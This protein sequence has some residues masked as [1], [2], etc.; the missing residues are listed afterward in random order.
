LINQVPTGVVVT[1]PQAYVENECT[2]GIHT[3]LMV[4]AQWIDGPDFTTIRLNGQNVRAYPSLVYDA[5]NNNSTPESR[6]KGLAADAKAAHITSS[7][8][9][10]VNQTPAQLMSI[11]A[12]DPGMDLK[13]PLVCYRFKALWSIYDTDEVD[14]L[15][16]VNGYFR[17]HPVA[18]R[19][20]SSFKIEWQDVNG[21]WHDYNNPVVGGTIPKNSD[22]THPAFGGIP[23]EGGDNYRAVFSSTFGNEGRAWP[24]ALKFSY[25]V[26]DPN[27]RLQ[28]GRDF[29]QVV[30]LP[31]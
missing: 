22:Y 31:D 16:F 11:I 9:A 21:E 3:T 20:L 15:P 4:Q 25:H 13:W 26:V 28:G 1:N 2:L 18:L 8:V 6:M 14:N 17:T 27:N 24:R 19:G 5:F 30:R 12:S 23:A 7:R 10:V 29:T